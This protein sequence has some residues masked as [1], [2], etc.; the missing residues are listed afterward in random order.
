LKIICST[1]VRAAK[2][3]D[4]HGGLYVVDIDSKEV[5]HYAPYEKDFVNDNERGGERGL[6]G[7][8]VLSD[9]IIVSDSAGFI[10]LD[11]KT[12]EIK[13]THQDRDYFKSI[14]EITFCDDHLWVT[15]TAY[16][17]VAKVDLDF[18]V[19][20]IWKMDGES[21]PNS[22]RL[23]GK[24]QID[25]DSK[26]ELDEYH[27][28]SIFTHNNK[29]KVSGLL[30][31]LHNLDDMSVSTPIPKIIN[32]GV[33]GYKNVAHSF[34]HNFYEYDDISLANLTTFSSLGIY[35]GEWEAVQIPRM[36]KAHFSIDEIA[37]NNW[38]RGLARKD[39]RV[40]IGSSPARLIIYNLETG[41]FEDEIQLAKDI[42]HAIHGLEILDEF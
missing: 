41:E 14:H 9:R 2:Q 10:E 36:K 26:E 15:S 22:K 23:T 5:I 31:D 24:T 29:V 17:A 33:G 32:Y 28:N 6:R 19:V 42:R 1:V 39:N 30:T 20:D 18:N 34:V 16:D 4:I 11:K 27:I 8:C 40:I 21:L 7:I 25:K 13:R 35:D 12:Y 38:N 3:G 37:V